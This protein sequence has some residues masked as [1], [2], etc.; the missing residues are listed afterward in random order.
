MKTALTLILF[1]V[2]AA[3]MGWQFAR[4]SP[5]AKKVANLE[6]QL[7]E[8][9]AEIESL[10]KQL[11]ETQ[12][13]TRPQPPL[14]RS[15]PKKPQVDS[16]APSEPAAKPSP[17]SAMREMMQN[18]EMKKAMHTQ[19][20]AQVLML[21]ADLI[22]HFQFN[23]EEKSHFEKLLLDRHMDQMEL[24]L[25]MAQAGLTP[26]KR[27]ELTRAYKAQK[28]TSDQAI[29]KFLNDEDD[30]ETFQEWEETQPERVQVQM[31]GRGLF[32][33]SDEPLTGDQ[34]A[35]LIEA[36]ADVRRAPPSTPNPGPTGSDLLQGSLNDERIRSALEVQVRNNT[37]IL[38]RATAF[39][40]P[41]QIETLKQ[42]Q[43]QQIGMM[44]AG[45]QMSKTLMGEDAR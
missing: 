40:S 14:A 11:I 13:Q 5:D 4:P 37:V 19:Q 17:T 9:Q 2:M 29:R 43:E 41:G 27:K 45:L 38:E 24:G 42:F 23:E 35:L 21:N 20:A 25:D 33:A 8:A 30:W 26:E 16:S 12:T 36:M 28:E 1:L 44:E 22:R 39:M 34:E 10:R 6:H 32:K 31:I 15:S 3:V 7:S 18:P